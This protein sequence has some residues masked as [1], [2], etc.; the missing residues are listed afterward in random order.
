MILT[1]LLA[2]GLA[3]ITM[4]LILQTGQVLKFSL[5]IQRDRPKLTGE[6]LETVKITRVQG[7]IL[8]MDATLS[9]LTIDGKNRSADLKQTLSQP[10]VTLSWNAFGQRSGG[11]SPLKF[12]RPVASIMP[13]LGEAGL[14]LCEF[15]NRAISIGDRWMGSVTATGGCTSGKY[16]LKGLSDVGGRRMAS[17]EVTEIGLYSGEQATPMTMIVD[18]KTGIPESVDYSV[19]SP[20]GVRSRFVQRLLNASKD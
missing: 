17:V 4:R 14:Y 6:I 20:T 13:W 15:P 19:V 1:T 8:T 18:L 3:P 12:D 11:M 7:G 5:T 2:L 9:G 10:T 16:Q